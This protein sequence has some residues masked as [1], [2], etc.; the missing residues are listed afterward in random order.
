MT[1]ANAAPYSTHNLRS[2]TIRGGDNDEWFA[3][4]GSCSSLPG[5]REPLCFFERHRVSFGEGNKNRLQIDSFA[6]GYSTGGTG[7]TSPSLPRISP[8][9]G[10]SHFRRTGVLAP[11]GRATLFS[12]FRVSMVI[13]WKGD[14]GNWRAGS[15]KMIR[16]HGR[17]RSYEAGSY[18]GG[19]KDV[20]LA[21]D[22]LNVERREVGSWFEIFWL[23]SSSSK[24]KYWVS[25]VAEREKRERFSQNTWPNET[26]PLLATSRRRR[27]EK[28]TRVQYN[29]NKEEKKECV[30]FS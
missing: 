9:S 5:I 26:L 28:R 6:K 13:S 29:K 19:I 3:Y 8:Q 14:H 1:T 24:I 4:F 15:R 11:V 17:S 12:G 30:S 18:G 16:N 27:Y 10:V 2:G 21:I 25:L 23:H 20:A 7:P 22:E